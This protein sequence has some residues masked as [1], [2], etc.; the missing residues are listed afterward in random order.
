MIGGA[1]RKR[2]LTSIVPLDFLHQASN[3]LQNI[4]AACGKRLHLTVRDGDVR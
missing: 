4:S 2:L 3:K 1:V